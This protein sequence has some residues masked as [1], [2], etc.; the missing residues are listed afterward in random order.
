[1]CKIVRNA[2]TLLRSSSNIYKMIY[3]CC[4]RCRLWNWNASWSSLLTFHYHMKRLMKNSINWYLIMSSATSWSSWR[5]YTYK[6]AKFRRQSSYLNCYSR[7]SQM[8]MF[9]LT[10]HFKF[11]R[12]PKF[13]SKPKQMDQNNN[14]SRKE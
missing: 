3:M 6:T 8:E 5:Q 1:M 11:C 4:L 10:S 9:W 12:T 2:I 7:M 13:K 14:T